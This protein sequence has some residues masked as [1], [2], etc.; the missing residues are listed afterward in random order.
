ASCVG[1]A[2]NRT[3]SASACKVAPRPLHS[4]KPT[5]PTI[6]D[7][8]REAGVGIGTVS[9][10]LNHSPFVSH[11]MRQRVLAAIERLGY[12]PSRVARAFGRRQTHTLEVLAPLF[13]GNFFLEILRGIEEAL[14]GDEYTLLART[15]ATAE[16]RQRAFEECC[17]RGSADGA[18]LLWT[19]PT[20]AL[21]D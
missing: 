14:T 20:D 13:L 4:A 2:S 8:A 21:L 19:P 16:D 15:L 7:V 11:D 6:D 10:V 3:G 12:Q 17:S 5:V 18:L 9:R 1:S